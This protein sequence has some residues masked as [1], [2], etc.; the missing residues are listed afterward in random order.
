MR[1]IHMTETFLNLP[2]RWKHSCLVLLYSEPGDRAAVVAL[3]WRPAAVAC[4]LTAEH[5]DQLR[6]TF[7]D[8]SAWA[9][10]TSRL[11]SGGGQERDLIRGFGD[12]WKR[13]ACH[14]DACDNASIVSL[15]RS[16]VI[17]QKRF[18]WPFL[19]G[20]GTSHHSFSMPQLLSDTCTHYEPAIR[21]ASEVLCL[22]W[23]SV[24][25]FFN[26]KMFQCR[27]K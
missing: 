27:R 23:W 14:T 2:F 16:F 10:K 15:L 13:K 26:M 9:G 18:E 25:V 6:L 21:E 12:T 24:V 8:H 20:K 4:R 7:P 17:A 19:F 5:G 1:S 22:L 3:G 11:I